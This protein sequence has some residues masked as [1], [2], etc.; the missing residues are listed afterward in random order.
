MIKLFNTKAL[1]NILIT[2]I[3]HIPLFMTT[4]SLEY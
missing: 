1:V 2:L 4:E 3:Y